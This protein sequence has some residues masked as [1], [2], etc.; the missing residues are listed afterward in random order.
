ML[1]YKMLQN[2][3][4]PKS[5]KQYQRKSNPFYSVLGSVI[6]LCQSTVYPS[7]SFYRLN[8]IYKNVET[9]KV[10]IHIYHINILIKKY[11]LFCGVKGI[12]FS[13]IL[14]SLKGFCCQFLYCIIEQ[15]YNFHLLVLYHS[16]HRLFHSISRILFIIF[17]TYKLLIM[18]NFYYILRN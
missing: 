9:G 15:M 8:Q 4:K 12:N 10:K 7:I 18:N 13:F 16:L 17:T 14:Y 11:I 5:I 2:F 1:L 6:S 3:I